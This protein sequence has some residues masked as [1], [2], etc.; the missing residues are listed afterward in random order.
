MEEQKKVVHKIPVPE[1]VMQALIDYLK[2]RP[3][4]EVFLHIANLMECAK[5]YN[6]ERKVVQMPSAPNNDKD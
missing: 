4:E 5:Q 3:Y 1:G 2:T 6:D